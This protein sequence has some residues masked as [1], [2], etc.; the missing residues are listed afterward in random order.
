M[1]FDYLSFYHG[2]LSNDPDHSI[3]DHLNAKQ[4][5]ICYSDKFAIWMFAI[6]IPTLQ[7]R[8]IMHWFQ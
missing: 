1:A 3:S 8:V 7:K 5:K 6:Q 4:V 2:R